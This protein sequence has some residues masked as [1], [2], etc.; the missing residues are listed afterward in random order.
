M[1]NA[2]FRRLF[3][4]AAPAAVAL[5]GTPGAAQDTGLGA[6]ARAS[7]AELE[8]MRGKFI[9]ADSVR[10]FGVTLHTLWQTGDGVVTAA[11]LGLSLWL[12][13]GSAAPEVVVSWTRDG[14]PG[15]NVAGFAP[16]AA[17]HYV[18]AGAVQTSVIA[19][20][21]NA[22]A[23]RMSLAIVPASS[24]ATAG[25][26][27][28]FAGTTTGVAADGDTIRFNAA[29]GQ[30][31]LAIHDAQGG[32]TV[33]QSITSAPGQLGQSILLTSDHNV[34]NNTMAVTLGIDHGQI[35]AG[36]NLGNALSA[37]KGHGF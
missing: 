17:S 27:G 23:N 5:S 10:F 1:P 20:S 18:T 29:N 14:D 36:V 34:V 12:G 13:D 25:T 15:M 31:G 2:V 32:G 24:V 35:A 9:A 16:D 21:D 3:V 30:F 22:A 4:L 19:G 37:M 26:G 28:S 11:T 7:D 33:A 6:A 8:T